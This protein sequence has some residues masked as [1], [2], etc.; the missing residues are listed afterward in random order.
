MTSSTLVM[1]TS[2]SNVGLGIQKLLDLEM[3]FFSLSE[4]SL[5][6]MDFSAVQSGSGGQTA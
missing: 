4:A 5:L 1:V 3:V 2:F 6:V